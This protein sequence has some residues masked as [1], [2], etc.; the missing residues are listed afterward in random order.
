MSNTYLLRDLKNKSVLVLGN[1]VGKAIRELAVRMSGGKGQLIVTDISN[2]HFDAL[3]ADLAAFHLSVEFIRTSPL[4]LAGIR[5]GS[6][7]LVI[8]NYALSA[9]NAIAGQGEL[10]LHKFYEVLKPGGTLYIEEELP[11]YMAASA[12]QAIW[13][14]KSR[15]RKTTQL[16]TTGRHANDYQ[17]DVLETLLTQAGFEKVEVSDEI[18][19][20]VTADWWADFV[21]QLTISLDSLNDE[22]LQAGLFARMERLKSAAEQAGSMEAPFITLTALKPW[23]IE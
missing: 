16:L 7:D 5:P 18:A 6:I 10:A 17:P 8:C 21:H 22:T 13:A 12:S 2:E 23:R 3:R 9:I 4:K 19:T 11:F 20:I 1:R 15:L 14:E